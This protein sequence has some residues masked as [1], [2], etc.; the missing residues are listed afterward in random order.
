MFHVASCHSNAHSDMRLPVHMNLY[1]Y[2]N[3]N[4]DDVGRKKR[5]IRVSKRNLVD[6]Q[7]SRRRN[8]CTSIGRNAHKRID[9]LKAQ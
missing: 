6:V 7:R 5:N 8:M 1:M 3:R 4:D 9:I 2:Y